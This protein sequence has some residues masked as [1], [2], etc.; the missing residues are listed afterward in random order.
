MANDSDLFEYEVREALL[1]VAEKEQLEQL[2]FALAQGRAPVEIARQRKLGFI[3]HEAL[4]QLEL[5]PEPARAEIGKQR[6]Q[7]GHGE[8]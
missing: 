6:F 5:M 1:A 3:L 2:H 7:L 8:H 4:N